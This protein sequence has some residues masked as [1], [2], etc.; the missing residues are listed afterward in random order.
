MADLEKH[1]I[2][3]WMQ[4][5]F[6]SDVINVATLQ[7]SIKALEMEEDAATNRIFLYELACIHP[8][9]SFLMWEE[10]FQKRIKTWARNN[11]SVPVGTADTFSVTSLYPLIRSE[12][13]LLFIAQGCVTSF[14]YAELQNHAMPRPVAFRELSWVS[15]NAEQGGALRYDETALKNFLYSDLS[16]V[17]V[18]VAGLKRGLFEMAVAYAKR[19]I[20]GG[21]AIH[22]WSEVQ[23]QL[24]HLYLIIQR[25]EKHIQLPSS[26]G[27]WDILSDVDQFVS[28]AMQI[29]GG[30]GYTE[31]YKAERYFRECI[32]LKN[33]LLPLK[34]TLLQKFSL[35]VL[36]VENV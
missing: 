19:R 24:S 15:L 18:L 25:D 30:V 27:A 35:E 34:E 20:Q 13:N 14:A 12:G 10:L 22:K 29:F 6:T 23:R 5:I 21:R 28:S 11:L 17:A 9:A 1:E 36:G 7:R 4:K 26:L 2:Q 31:D 3:S 33:W 16:F 32:F 8:L